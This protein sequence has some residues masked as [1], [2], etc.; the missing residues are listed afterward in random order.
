MVCILV[1]QNRFLAVKLHFNFFLVYFFQLLIIMSLS[2]L[3]VSILEQNSFWETVQNYKISYQDQQISRQ[4]FLAKIAETILKLQTQLNESD[5]NKILAEISKQDKI[6]EKTVI[7]GNGDVSS[8][9]MGREM[10]SSFGVDGVMI[11]RGILTNPYLFA[12]ENINEKSKLEKLNLLL[13]HLDLWQKIWGQNK[14]FPVLKK[15]FKIYVQG[16]GG[17]VELRTKLMESVSPLEVR[18]IIQNYLQNNL[19]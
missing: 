10:A 14:K 2:P 11:G 9:S 15:Y 6:K 19:I 17:A 4:E 8:L 16:F 1:F 5:K 18:Q 12:G 7:I 13:F 3:F